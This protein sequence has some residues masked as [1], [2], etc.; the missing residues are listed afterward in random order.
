MQDATVDHVPLAIH[1]KTPIGRYDR[2]VDHRAAHVASELNSFLSSQLSP[3][4]HCRQ[5]PLSHVTTRIRKPAVETRARAN[6]RVVVVWPVRAHLSLNGGSFARSTTEK[7]YES[8]A[9][10]GHGMMPQQQVRMSNE[11]VD[12][13]RQGH[14]TMTSAT[15]N[16]DVTKPRRRLVV[17]LPRR[18]YGR[19]DQAQVQN[20]RRNPNVTLPG[21]IRLVAQ[22]FVEPMLHEWVVKVHVARVV[23]RDRHN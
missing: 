20:L 16:H 5:P 21:R 12:T 23:S 8:H 2:D 14:R 19:G 11:E 9:A 6:A 18:R 4:P 7:R 1:A 15:F 10:I 22:R 3:L 17:R 13:V